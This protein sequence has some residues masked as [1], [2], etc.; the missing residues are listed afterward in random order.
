MVS[1][2]DTLL[3]DVKTSIYLVSDG[4][5]SAKIITGRSALQDRFRVL[6]GKFEELERYLRENS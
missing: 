5:S 1:R 3:A 6:K 4:I 2:L